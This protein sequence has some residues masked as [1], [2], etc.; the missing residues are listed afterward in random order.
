MGASTSPTDDSYPTTLG[1]IKKGDQEQGDTDN[2][3]HNPP[4]WLDKEKFRRGQAFFKNHASSLLLSLHF[5]LTTGFCITN[6]LE[7]LVFT[8]KSDTGPKAHKRYYQ[9]SLHLLTWVFEEIWD[10]PKSL[11]LRSIKAVRKMHKYVGKSMTKKLAD[12]GNVYV[13]Q[14][15]MG[16]VQSGFMGAIIMYP[17]GFGCAC[18]KSDLE[19]YIHF[20]RGMGWLLGID[21][22]YNICAGNYEQTHSIVKSIERDML[23]PGL[24]NPPKDFYMMVK[25][26]IDGVNMWSPIPIHSF[27]SIKAMSM[28]GMGFSV[29]SLSW[30]DKLRFWFFKWIVFMLLWCP[31]FE[32]LANTSVKR[33]YHKTIHELDIEP[34]GYN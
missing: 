31:G 15:D 34:K 5:S 4:S 11:A 33:F 27:E 25:A 8:K 32:R 24:A 29:P 13:S 28:E 19:D 18:N 30:A 7:P 22:K 20:W 10:N 2:S 1:D 3:F 12:T 17:E 6:L 16:I 9:T 14:Y 26:Y 23:L 21:D